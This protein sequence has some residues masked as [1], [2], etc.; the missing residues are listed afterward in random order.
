V[1]LIEGVFTPGKKLYIS[2]SPTQLIQSRPNGGDPW[3]VSAKNVN[4]LTYGD[5]IEFR[6]PPA[7]GMGGLKKISDC[8]RPKVC[9]I[10]GVLGSRV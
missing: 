1:K 10:F 4:G 8:Q 7:A 2:N 3:P 6:L 5:E 9:Q